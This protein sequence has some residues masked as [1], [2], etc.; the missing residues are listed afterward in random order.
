MPPLSHYQD[1]QE[2]L[3][4]YQISD[5][6]KQVLDRMR[7]VLLLAPTSGGRNTIIRQRVKTGHYHYVISDTTRPPRANDG[8]MEQNGV[9]YWFR[10]EKE[11]LDDLKK[12]EYLEAEIIHSQQVSGIS[13]R[14]LEN[15]QKEGKIAITDIEL[16][17]I[18]NVL[19]GKPDTIAIMLLPPSFEEWQRRL[20]GR[21]V[22]RPDEQ[23][24]RL[25]TALRIFQDGLKQDYY[26]FVISDDINQTGGII[27]AIVEGKPNPH[28][29]RGRSL[30]EHL[31]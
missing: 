3:E 25:E 18:H 7:L 21:G 11:I 24:R 16:K 15:A 1:F 20:A 22:M 12:G 23:K 10:S 9:E 13:I 31:Q 14:E 8:V 4:N 19:R 26:H 6:A 28:Q 5:R 27:D 30:I 17:G 29:G 2:I